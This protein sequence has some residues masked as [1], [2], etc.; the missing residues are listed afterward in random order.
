MKK[1]IGIGILV[2]SLIMIITGVVLSTRVVEY[3]VKFTGITPVK[4]EKVKSGSYVKRPDDP[5]K[6][7]STFIGWYHNDKLFDFNSKI[8]NEYVVITP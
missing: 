1:K 6:E 4:S 8:S 5:V 2:L 7:G 3:T